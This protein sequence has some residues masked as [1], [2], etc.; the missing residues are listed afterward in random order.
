MFAL[1]INFRLECVSIDYLGLSETLSEETVAIE[2]AEVSLELAAF[3]N[4]QIKLCIWAL[5]VAIVKVDGVN[6]VNTN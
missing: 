5:N 2:D 4:I 6:M 1:R 3:N